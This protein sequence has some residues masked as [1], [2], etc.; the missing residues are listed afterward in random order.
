MLWCLV[1]GRETTLG[2]VGAPRAVRQK[3]DKR[4]VEMSI[5]GD[6]KEDGEVPVY[7]ADKGY[8]ESTEF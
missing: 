4:S 6:K 1:T 8:S 2:E 5:F 3:V 7:I